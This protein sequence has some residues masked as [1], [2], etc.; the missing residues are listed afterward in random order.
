MQQKQKKEKGKGA[1]RHGRLYP[2]SRCTQ[3][4][5]KVPNPRNLEALNLCVPSTSKASGPIMPSGIIKVPTVKKLKRRNCLHLNPEYS[6]KN[7][8]RNYSNYNICSLV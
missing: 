4:P 7:K 1:N 3:D 5:D 2:K 8:K 6:Q